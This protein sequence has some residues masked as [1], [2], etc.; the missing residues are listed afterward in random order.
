VNDERQQRIRYWNERNNL[1]AYALT[2]AFILQKDWKDVVGYFDRMAKITKAEVVAFANARFND[3]SVSV[4]KRTG[5]DSTVFHVEKPTITPLDINRAEQSEWYKHW[6]SI[7]EERLQPEYVDYGTAITRRTLKHEIP[8]AIIP[9]TS[10]ELFTLTQ[11]L[12]LGDYD[13]PKLKLAVNY[14]PYLGT[15]DRSAEELQKEFFKLGLDFSVY[16]GQDRM[17]VS[18]SGLGEN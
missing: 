8:L 16:A 2:D 4:Y 7:P 13:T 14:L 17:Y 1:R 15:A 6:S 9:N 12:D 3:N 18:L 10:N 11:V 5:S